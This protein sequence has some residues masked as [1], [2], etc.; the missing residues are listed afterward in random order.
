MK[1]AIIHENYPFGG[2][3]EVTRMLSAYLVAKDVRIFIYSCTFSEFDKKNGTIN[4]KQFPE[5]RLQ[6]PKNADFLIH[7]I[8]DNQI[9]IL[10]V[11]DYD[12][13]LLGHIK[14]ETGCKIVFAL[15]S[16]PFWEIIFKYQVAKRRSKK[17]FLN[18][19]EWYI[20][21][22]FRY[23]V[24]KTHIKKTNKK[25]LERCVLS[26]KYVTLTD[27][28]TKIIQ[29]RVNIKGKELFLSISNPIAIP[30]NMDLTHKKKEIIYVGRLSYADKRVDRLLDIWKNIQINFPDWILRI[31]GDGPEK[32]NLESKVISEGV[33][34]VFFEGYKE[35]VSS[36]YENASIICM[37]SSFE[38]WPLVLGEAQSYG[39]VPVAFN[40]SAG[41]EDILSPDGI[42]GVLVPPFDMELYA[43]ELSRLMNNEAERVKIAKA[44][45]LKSKEY[46]LDVVGQKW[47]NLFSSLISQ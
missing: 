7:E 47:L 30:E 36:Y 29:D 25:Y 18:L 16:A 43:K 46:S 35:N 24:L 32:V 41:V 13:P 17:S 28:Y 44:A 2:K 31:I 38:G 4:Y 1:I 6:S 23:D 40:C 22:R 3:E 11:P 27:K 26:D 34:N 19:L 20:I 42:N 8:I 45:L 15:H 5:I 37:T 39:V 21:Q 14:E 9:D 12:L 33:K 10:L